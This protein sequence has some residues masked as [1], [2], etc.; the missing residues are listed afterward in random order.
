MNG[1]MQNNNSKG[2]K[3]LTR[4][5]RHNNT[6]RPVQARA[7]MHMKHSKISPWQVPELT[8][9]Q[10]VEPLPQAGYSYSAV[11]RVGQGRH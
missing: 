6:V 5:T 7:L 3:A 2:H 8:G 11:S 10:W 1:D 9:A 4:G